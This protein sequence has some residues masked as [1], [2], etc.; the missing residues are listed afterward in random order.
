MAGAH[1]VRAAL[2]WT[3][4]ESRNELCRYDPLR[5]CRRHGDKTIA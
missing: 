5:H 4:I 1:W 3:C 2:P